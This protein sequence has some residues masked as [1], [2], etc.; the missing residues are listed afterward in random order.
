MIAEVEHPI[1]RKKKVWTSWQIC[2]FFSLCIHLLLC[3]L[4]RDD[5]PP[6]ASEKTRTVQLRLDRHRGEKKTALK[7]EEKPEEESKEKPFAKTRSE[8][9][10]P[11]PVVEPDYIG[12]HR[13]R[14][15]GESQASGEKNQPTMTGEKP[16]N[17]TDIVFF[18]Q[19]AQE[20]PLEHDG[21]KA[22]PKTSPPPSPGV[23]PPESLQTQA[24]PE[25]NLTPADQAIA[26]QKE[27]GEEG[28]PDTPPQDF[29]QKDAAPQEKKPSEQVARDLANFAPPPLQRETMPNERIVPIPHDAIPPPMLSL[30]ELQLPTALDLPHIPSLEQGTKP[31]SKTAVYDPAFPSDAQPGFRT[32]ERKTRSSGRFVMGSQA[33]LNVDASPIG[34][35][36]AWI[37]R[38]IASRWYKQCDI[39][40]EFI[41]PGSLR[42]RLLVNTRGQVTSMTA[43]SQQGA[44]ATQ[45]AF[46]FLAIRQAPIP[47]MPPE[48]KNDLVGDSLELIFDFH[49]D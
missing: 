46:T 47:A 34:R 36:E 25:L 39:N 7:K 18:D 49:F 6:P 43:L 38:A 22:Q 32:Q 16:K 45:R 28:D 12:A 20:G 24:Q 8:D 15:Q 17:K 19:E 2:L 48:V 10:T 37:Y 5:I 33:K 31:Q 44:S 40:R 11:Y 23:T 4:W 14:G 26:G 9:S 13:T 30:K 21:A 1:C 41:I 29:A 35:F 27:G 3:F 42:I